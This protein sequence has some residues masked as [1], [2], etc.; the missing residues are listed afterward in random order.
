MR[1]QPRSGVCLRSRVT[2]LGSRPSPSGSYGGC[3]SCH[4]P[5]TLWS[6]AP[7]GVRTN[8]TLVGVAVLGEDAQAGGSREER[9][10]GEN[11]PL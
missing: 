6:R 2:G 7:Q 10:G 1:L 5:S 11:N 8:A 9:Q 3:S 4:F